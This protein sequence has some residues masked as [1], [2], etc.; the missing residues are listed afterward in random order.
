[1]ATDRPRPHYWVVST[2]SL[3]GMLRRAAA[4]EDPDLV[5]AEAYANAERHEDVGSRWD[6]CTV[7]VPSGL[8]APRTYR[9]W[10]PLPCP[11]HGAPAPAGG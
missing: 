1:M 9:C 7:I 6:R 2:A 11:H 4:G 10:W 3:L 5:V 8:E